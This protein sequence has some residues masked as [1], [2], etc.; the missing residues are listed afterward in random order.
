MLHGSKQQV[1]MAM[2]CY[3]K[4]VLL[5]V[6]ELWMHVSWRCKANVKGGVWYLSW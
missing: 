6:D 5:Y 2:K 3:L 4:S 1:Q